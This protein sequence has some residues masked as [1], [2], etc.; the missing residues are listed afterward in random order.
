MALIKNCLDEITFCFPV[1]I[2]KNDVLFFTTWSKQISFMWDCNIVDS[3]F[4]LFEGSDLSACWNLPYFNCLIPWTWNQIVLI[5]CKNYR[6]DVVR[7]SFEGF[8]ASHFWE[9]PYFD[10]IVTWT[11]RQQI[12]FI[13]DW[14]SLNFSCMTFQ[15]LCT[16]TCINIPN[17]NTTVLAS[18]EQGVLNRM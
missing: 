16:F 11:R 18:T 5:R 1:C 12:P 14:N 3:S 7:M 10:L 9:I 6:R 4:M 13:T 2:P 8:N 17:F 15:V